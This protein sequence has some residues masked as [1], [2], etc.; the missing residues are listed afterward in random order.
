MLKKY[1]VKIK[2]RS[3]Y[4]KKKLEEEERNDPMLSEVV[5]DKTVDGKI[6]E[7]P[8]DTSHENSKDY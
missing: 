1:D 8:F 2:K 5:E 6:K 3:V 4:N 7:T